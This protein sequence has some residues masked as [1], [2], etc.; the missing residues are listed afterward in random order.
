MKLKAEN[1]EIR[2]EKRVLLSRMNFEFCEGQLVGLIGPSGCG[3]TTLLNTLG[4]LLPAHCGSIF[5]DGSEATQWSRRQISAF[6]RNQAS[7]V[8]QNAGIDDDES[9]LYNVTLK[10]SLFGG[11]ESERAGLEALEKVGLAERAHDKARV[12]SGGEQ[13][14]VAIARSIYRQS[15]VIFADEPTASLDEE[16]RTLIESLLVHEAKRGTLVIISTHDMRLSQ[17]CTSLVDLVKYQPV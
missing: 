16:N 11:H 10:K 6:W 17:R 2:V 9:V 15:S 13:R 12:L 7:F 3:K 5:Y 8:I 1:L 14:R 4:L